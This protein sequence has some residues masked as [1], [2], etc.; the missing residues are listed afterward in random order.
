MV[1]AAD[2]PLQII[3]AIVFVASFITS[4]T[5]VDKPFT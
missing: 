3:R 2:E 5:A 4:A 1:G